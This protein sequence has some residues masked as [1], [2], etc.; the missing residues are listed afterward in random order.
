MEH[1]IQP[2]VTRQMVLNELV[3]VG[4]DRDIADDLSYRYYKNELTTK[5]LELLKMAF[6]SDIRDLNNKIDTVENNLNIKIDTK[7]NELDNKIDTVENNLKSD[8]RDLNNKIDTVENN[9]NIKIDTKFNELDNKIDIIENNLKSEISLVRKDM[10]LIRKDMEINKTELNSKLKL[11]NWMLGTIITINVG[12][13][14][15]L[16]SIINSIINK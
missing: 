1:M 2:V 8:I 10:D 16:I 12:I 6:K 5:D 14:L 11:N 9:L 3:K 15:T 4:M 7:F 13:L